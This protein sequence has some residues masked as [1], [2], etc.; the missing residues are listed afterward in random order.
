MQKFAP[1][2][3]FSSLVYCMKQKSFHKSIRELV[4]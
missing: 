4:V 3:K 1:A 2:E